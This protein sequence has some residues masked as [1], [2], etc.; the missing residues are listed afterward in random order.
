MWLAKLRTFPPSS[1]WITVDF[2]PR[3][4]TTNGPLRRGRTQ[5]VLV[6]HRA[7]G[8]STNRFA[9][10]G[11]CRRGQQRLTTLYTHGRRRVGVQVKLLACV[12]DGQLMAGSVP[13]RVGHLVVDDVNGQSEVLPAQPKSQSR[14]AVG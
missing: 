3:V 12:A 11:L 10:G 6:E 2:P 13:Q 8:R 1:C 5:H 7:E 4:A 9:A 14:Y